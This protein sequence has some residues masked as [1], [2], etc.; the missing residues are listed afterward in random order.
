MKFIFAVLGLALI[1]QG[2]HAAETWMTQYD[3]QFTFECDKNL[4]LTAILSVHDSRKEDRVFNF[5]CDAAPDVTELQGCE[6]SGKLLQ[7]FL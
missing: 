1:W 4:H 6:W 2:A 7:P 3:Q 5:S